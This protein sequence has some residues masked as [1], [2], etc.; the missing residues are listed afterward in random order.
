MIPLTIPNATARYTLLIAFLFFSTLCLIAQSN[1]DELQLMQSLYGMDKR[2]IISEFVELSDNQQN[3]F[4]Q[5]YDEYESKRKELGK[6]RFELINKYVDDFGQVSATDAD[7]FMKEAIQLRIKSDNLRDSYYK[8]IKART[9]P[10]VAMQFYQ[11]ERYL[12]DL[13]RIEILEEVY[14]SKKP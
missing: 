13:I 7:N 1:D 9:D 14:T 3:G 5:L 6:R 2:E 12:S 4:W 10:V 11:I 8:K